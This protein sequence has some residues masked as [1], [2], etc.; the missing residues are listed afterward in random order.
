MSAPYD[1]SYPIYDLLPPGYTFDDWLRSSPP[2]T[3]H[4]LGL[5][6]MRQWP[7]CLPCE[8]ITVRLRKLLDP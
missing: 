4:I 2:V 8:I 5:I 6:G 3:G 7:V 1:A